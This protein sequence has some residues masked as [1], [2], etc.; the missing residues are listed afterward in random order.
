M[1]TTDRDGFPVYCNVCGK[2]DGQHTYHCN[3]DR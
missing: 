1:A 3:N 2:E